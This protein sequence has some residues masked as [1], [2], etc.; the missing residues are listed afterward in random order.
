M[1]Y[2]RPQDFSTPGKKSIVVTASQCSGQLCRVKLRIHFLSPLEWRIM[3]T[4]S[5]WI[6][7]HPSNMLHLCHKAPRHLEKQYCHRGK[8][9]FWPL[10]LQQTM[11]TQ[12]LHTFWAHC[13][14][15]WCWLTLSGYL[16]MEDALPWTTRLFDTWKTMNGSQNSGHLYW[17]K[18]WLYIHLEPTIVVQTA[19]WLQLDTC[20]PIEDAL[21][22]TTELFHTWKTTSA[23]IASQNDPWE[24]SSLLTYMVPVPA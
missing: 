11:N 13:S 12:F 6:P 14:S 18:P 3:Q 7:F 9:L 21:P 19:E 17:I 10:I 8:S 20:S 15:R 16:P 2:H 5:T 23:T 24:T 1:L 4:A 22:W